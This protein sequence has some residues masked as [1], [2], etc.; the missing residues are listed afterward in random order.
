MTENEL[1]KKLRAQ[2]ATIQGNGSM[3]FTPVGVAEDHGMDPVEAQ[4]MLQRLELREDLIVLGQG[5][6]WCLPQDEHRF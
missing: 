5:E 3:V 2:R 1:L 4:Q 6:M